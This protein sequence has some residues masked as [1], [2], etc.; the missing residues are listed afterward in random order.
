MITLCPM[1]NSDALAARL[2]D[3]LGG[4]LGTVEVHRFP[5]GE[6][7][8][9]VSP[10]GRHAA[11]VCS[12]DDPDPKLLPVLFAAATLRE[13]G[14]ATVGLIAPYLAYMR[15]DTRF[16]PGEAV[17][18]RPFAAVLSGHF[19]WLV[20]VDPHL[21]RYPNLEALYTLPCEVVHAAPALA[22]WIAAT[23]ADPVLI[24][25]DEESRQWVEAVAAAIPAPAVVLGKTRLGDRE[26]RLTLPDM[27]PWKART[28]V[29]VDDI[30]STGHTL[31][32][33]AAHL[34]A[35][36]LAPPLCVGVHGLFAADATSALQEAGITH[37]ATTDTVPGPFSR[38][39]LDGEIAQAVRRVTARLPTLRG[40]SE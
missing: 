2:V 15:Q 20:T 39:A 13:L 5:D 33:A 12:L 24:G 27:S 9:R 19:D 4:A 10:P 7:R 34:R 36:D 35:A 23:V 38:I 8:V 28:P 29:L 31:A 3:R 30:I 32:A 16:Q 1:W 14:A 26:V 11:I 18:S 25:P 40:S 21:H 37:I 17:S 6:S 22:R